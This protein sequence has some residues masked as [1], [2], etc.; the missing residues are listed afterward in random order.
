[1]YARL[2][3]VWVT[4]QPLSVLWHCWL[5]HQTCKKYHLWM[6]YN[7]GIRQPVSIASVLCILAYMLT[8]EL[9][10][11]NIIIIKCHDI[12]CRSDVFDAKEMKMWSRSW[13]KMIPDLHLIKYV[14]TRCA[15][16]V[17]LC[18][19]VCL[20]VCCLA[21]MCCSHLNLVQRLSL[22]WVA[23]EAVLRSKVREGHWWQKRVFS[24][25]WLHCDTATEPH[26]E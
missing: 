6:T 3:T 5:G 22:T 10:A 26:S 12:I 21:S 14:L 1:M 19:S 17:F 13:S 4:R 16:L 11:S 2:R 25:K 18:L 15:H 23:V 20:S 8:P 7:T 9:V 24:L